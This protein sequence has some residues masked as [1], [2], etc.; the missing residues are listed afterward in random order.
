[1]YQTREFNVYDIRSIILQKLAKY[2]RVGVKG[3]L[4]Q[5]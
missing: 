5:N 4:D 1:M 2:L 3:E